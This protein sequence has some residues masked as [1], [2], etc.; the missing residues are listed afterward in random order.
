MYAWRKLYLWCGSVQVEASLTGWNSSISSGVLFFSSA[1]GSSA[2]RKR[3][4]LFGMNALV[5]RRLS[6]V[7]CGEQSGC[8]RRN[9]NHKVTK[10]KRGKWWV[11]YG[12]CLAL[13]EEK[14]VWRA[15]TFPNSWWTVYG[16]KFGCRIWKPVSGNFV[17]RFFIPQEI[18]LYFWGAAY[19]PAS[20][21]LC[22]T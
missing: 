9:W 4:K 6:E 11:E 1:S 17:N 22:L 21:V 16:V 19:I 13:E 15:P 7:S 14:N 2:N 3:P 20:L 5:L 18:E 8:S 12:S 10:G